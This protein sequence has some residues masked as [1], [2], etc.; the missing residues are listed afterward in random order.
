ME[1]T[2]QSLRS[3]DD[4]RFLAAIGKAVRARRVELGL[5]Q[6]KLA[7]M[8]DHHRNFVGGIER[9]EQNV[10]VLGLRRLAGALGC[11]EHD[12]LP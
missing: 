4:I 8:S 2:A 9:G 1:S 12:L 6:E 10:S 5:S 7:E 3:D 11:S